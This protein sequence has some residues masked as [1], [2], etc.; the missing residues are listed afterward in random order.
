[1]KAEGQKPRMIETVKAT[2]MLAYLQESFSRALYEVEHY[3]DAHAEARMDATI[4]Q[5]EL[6]EAM[7][8]APVNLRMDNGKVTV[9]FDE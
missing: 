7:I 4:A 1:M 3:H 9:G 8:G 2:T 5:K 6:V